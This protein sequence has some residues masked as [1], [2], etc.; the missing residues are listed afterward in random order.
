MSLVDSLLHA[1]G[2][3]RTKLAAEVNSGALVTIDQHIGE[4]YAA[5]T[6]SVDAGEAAAHKIL[7]GL[8]TAFHGSPIAVAPAAAA[9]PASSAAAPTPEPTP[10]A[11]STT[12]APAAPEAPAAPSAP[13]TTAVQAEP[14]APE[15]PAQ[16]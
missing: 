4:L 2:Q 15:T 9:E 3:F 14:A 6:A 16:S 10:A 7:S 8:Y 5:A 11:D 1:L 12:S 13:T